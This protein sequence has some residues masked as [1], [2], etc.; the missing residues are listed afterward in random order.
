MA[1]KVTGFS[2]KGFYDA[3]TRTI[4]EISK[5]EEKVFDL[6]SVLD[7]FDGKEISVSIKEDISPTPLHADE[8]DEANEEYDGEE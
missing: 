1:K 4:T 3:E 5:D 2:F 8:A 7:L 6:Q